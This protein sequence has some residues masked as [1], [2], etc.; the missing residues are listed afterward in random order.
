[1]ASDPLF[2][3]IALP[4]PVGLPLCR[5]HELRRPRLGEADLLTRVPYLF[6]AW[7]GY[8]GDDGGRI[9][10]AIPHVSYPFTKGTNSLIGFH[11]PAV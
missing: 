4:C 9:L 11:S 3:L 8:T 5:R 7:L 1:M 10:L 2:S 6:G